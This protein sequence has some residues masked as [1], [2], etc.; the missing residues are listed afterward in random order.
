M[1]PCSKL[2]PP[3]TQRNQS[4][5]YHT[6][7]LV[8]ARVADVCT[9]HLAVFRQNWDTKVLPNCPADSEPRAHAPWRGTRAN[10]DLLPL[11]M[12][13]LDGVHL[14]ACTVEIPQERV[15]PCPRRPDLVGPDTAAWRLAVLQ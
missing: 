9:M 7:L 6:Q 13:C 15:K 8:L 5:Q 12:V 4:G 11:T 10:V 2:L 3:L 1:L 14:P